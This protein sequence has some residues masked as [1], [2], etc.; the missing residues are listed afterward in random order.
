MLKKGSETRRRS[1]H[2]SSVYMYNVNF[3]RIRGLCRL[4]HYYFLFIFLI[5]KE[6]KLLCMEPTNCNANDS[7]WQIDTQRR[8]ENNRALQKVITNTRKNERNKRSRVSPSHTHTHSRID[9][10]LYIKRSVLVINAHTL[11][12]IHLVWVCVLFGQSI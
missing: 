10:P 6:T 11:I 5:S 8:S 3:S 4:F 1:R 12:D 2:K 9:V 7:S